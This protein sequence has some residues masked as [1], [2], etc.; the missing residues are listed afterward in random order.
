MADE[1]F[2]QIEQEL[3]SSFESQLPYQIARASLV[4]HLKLLPNH[5]FARA[6]F[7][8]RDMFIAGQYFGCISLCQAVAEALIR[9]L[10]T[11]KNVTGS[12]VLDKAARLEKRG[13]IAPKVRVA[14]RT[15]YAHDRNMFH[16]LTEDVETDNKRL[17]ERAQ[18]CV[19][20][21]YEVESSIFAYIESPDGERIGV[22]K[23]EYWGPIKS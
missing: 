17:G 21:L 1:D 9:F 16:H 15:I 3:R 22:K 11:V 4:K 8:C 14:V 20:A 23:P 6:S 2:E 5:H 10:C 12:T 7:E 19:N 18:E 13:V